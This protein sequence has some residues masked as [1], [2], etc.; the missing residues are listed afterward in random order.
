MNV[1]IPTEYKRKL[2]LYKESY[3]L[4]LDIYL[5]NVVKF[6]KPAKTKS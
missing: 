2:T 1:L 3:T 5:S 4:T 6:E